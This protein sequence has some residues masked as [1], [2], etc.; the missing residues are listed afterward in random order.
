[1]DVIYCNEGMKALLLARKE[2]RIILTRNTR[3]KDKENTFFIESESLPAQLRI[4][5]NH[6][7]LTEKLNFFSR[8][9]C[10]NEPLVCVEKE[11]IKGRVPYYT[12]K[13]F[14]EFAECPKCQRVY[15]KG[16]HYQRM[17]REIKKIIE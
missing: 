5:I 4:I 9:L 17:L 10:C 1:M 6:F 11:K 8:C 16:S 14:D 13:N 2:E 7:A 3:L 15:W 12:Y